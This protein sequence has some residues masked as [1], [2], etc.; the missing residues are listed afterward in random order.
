MNT[1]I[2]A[3]CLCPNAAKQA[4]PP[5]NLKMGSRFSAF[6]I[7]PETPTTKNGCIGIGWAMG[8]IIVFGAIH[9]RIV[10]RRKLDFMLAT[11]TKGNRERSR[12]VALNVNEIPTK[13]IPSETA[14]ADSGPLNAKSNISARFLGNDCIGVMHPKKGI[15]VKWMDGIGMDGPI[16]TCRFF[17]TSHPTASWIH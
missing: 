7:R 5:S 2:I 15:V 4:R 16:L 3:P 6:V 8:S 9:E 13:T 12:D 10:P 17:A 11:V 14:M 1:D